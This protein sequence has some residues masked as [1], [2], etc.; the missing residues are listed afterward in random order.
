MEQQDYGSDAGRGRNV[1]R[2]KVKKWRVI[3][4]IESMVTEAIM[5]G[6]TVD[7]ALKNFRDT[8]GGYQIYS[9]EEL[10]EEGCKECQI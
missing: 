6:D 9:I 8:K 3:Y 5:S 7:E 2:W 10:L 4:W 1:R